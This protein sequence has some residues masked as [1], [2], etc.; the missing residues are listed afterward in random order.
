MT[1]PSV[2][3]AGDRQPDDL[4]LDAGDA[5]LVISTSE[6]GR[7]RSLVVNGHELIVTEGDGSIRWGC[8]PM[9]PWAG[10]IRDGRFRFHDRAVQLPRN[11]APHAI[12]GTVFER[13]WTVVGPDTLAIDLGPDWPFAGR[14]HQ[15]FALHPGGLEAELVL[16]ADEPMPG[17]VGWHPWFRRVLAGTT[18]RPLAPSPPVELRFH[19]E[20]MYVRG[21]D[22][23]PTG[24]LTIP[25]PHPWDDCF[26]GVHSA[27][28]L[29]WADV[30]G[31]ELRSS[32]DHWVVYDEPVAAI[33]VEPQTAPPDFPNIAPSTVEPGQP[34][35][36]TMAWRWWALDGTGAPS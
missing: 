26:T 1:G 18:E 9:A 29:T 25:G 15:R 21:E 10:R 20:R 35:R 24:A 28:R 17:A 7:I 5:R 16:E 2:S 33:C 11:M 23:L 32:A 27:P 34:L 3:G 4:I 12:H 36:A 30:L 14:V 8:Y 22:G 19:A 31:L 13:P 6:G